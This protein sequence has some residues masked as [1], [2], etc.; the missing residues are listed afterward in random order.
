MNK[1]G[2]IQEQDGATSSRRFLAVVSYLNAIALSWADKPWESIAIFAGATL[3][4]LGLTTV[5]EIKSFTQ[6]KLAD[7]V[8][9]G[10]VGGEAEEPIG[11]KGQ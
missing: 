9:G 7:A 11:F 5:Q 2:I 8:G 4:L 10:S 3:I 1:A 6:Y